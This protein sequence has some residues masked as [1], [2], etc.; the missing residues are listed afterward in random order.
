MSD[1]ELVHSYNS[2]REKILEA[3]GELANP[4][5]ETI[6]PQGRNV[7]F[8]S[9]NGQFLSTNDGVTIA[10]HIDSNDEIKSGFIQIIKEAALQTNNRVGDGTSTS[11]LLSYV[12]LKEMFNMVDDDVGVIEIKEQLETYRDLMLDAIDELKMENINNDMLYNIANISANNDKS[13]AKKVMEIID[14]SGTDGMVSLEKGGNKTEL[15]IDNGFVVNGGILSPDFLKE[16]GSFSAE[17]ENVPVLVTN[18]RLYYKNEVRKIME[19]VINAG[20]E[21]VIIVARDFI[22]ESEN[23]LSALHQSADSNIR[24]ILP[25]K[26]GLATNDDDTSI[27][28]LGLYLNGSSVSDSRGEMVT[29]LSIDDFCVAKSVKATPQKTVIERNEEDN[30]ELDKHIDGLREK[31]EENKDDQAIGRRLAALT[32][33]MV[34]VKVGADTDIEKTESLFR[35]EDAI[36]ATRSSMKYG[37]LRG[38][39]MSIWTAWNMISD[40]AGISK[41]I[42]KISSNFKRS[43]N[44]VSTAP[45]EQILKN[46]DE[47]KK[48]IMDDLFLEAQKGCSGGYNAKTR[49]LGDLLK[50]GVV[51]PVRVT[52]Q[53]ISNA[54]S[55]VKQIITSNYLVLQ[56]N[57]QKEKGEEREERGE[58]GDK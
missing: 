25:I 38:G 44:R 4:V 12:L 15:D 31:K 36:N 26:D 56:Q 50:E 2:I 49:M 7:I 32:N 37:A 52:K 45:I 16:A 47:P 9:K 8:Q 58:G 1:K 10:K 33:G 46:S 57:E 28:D 19:V 6:S 22:G 30:P 5:M 13:I 40:D 39:G 35:Y 55:V 23:S 29:N 51:D 48:D 21:D 27:S 18:K 20:Y 41:D 42:A 24:N 17:Y 54:T 43:F 53:S 14:I 3:A 11:I 34:T